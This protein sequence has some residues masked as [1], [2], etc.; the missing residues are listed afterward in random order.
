MNCKFSAR[1]YPTGRRS[2][3]RVLL[4]LVV[5]GFGVTACGGSDEDSA[6]DR[7]ATLVAESPP[8]SDGMADADGTELAAGVLSVGA[9]GSAGAVDDDDT[10]EADNGADTDGGED[11]EMSTELTLDDAQLEFAACMRETYPEWPDPL[12]TGGPVFDPESLSDLG[13][14][15]RDESVREELRECRSVF[16]GVAGTGNQPTPEEQAER[17]DMQLALFACVRA[18]PGYEWLP[19]PDFSSGGRGLGGMRKIF[20]S[21]GVNL[22]ELMGLMRGCQSELGLEVGLE[23][24]G[25]NG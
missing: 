3:A 8:E 15:L 2:V 18:E 6:D 25:L 10:D 9:K 14:D 1:S 11:V 20:Q 16:E 5:L 21:R 4:P 24:G 19:D 7:I 23:G 17:E 12:S 13:I 22:R